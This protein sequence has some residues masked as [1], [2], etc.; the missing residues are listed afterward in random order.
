MASIGCYF[1]IK[2]RPALTKYFSGVMSLLIIVGVFE[3]K[4]FVYK[5]SSS[6]HIFLSILVLVQGISFIGVC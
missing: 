2:K 5:I 1:L 6:I 3:A 4:A